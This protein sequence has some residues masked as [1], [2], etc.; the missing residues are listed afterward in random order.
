MPDEYTGGARNFDLKTD[1]EMLEGV[2]HLRVRFLGCAIVRVND[3][4]PRTTNQRQLDSVF[5]RRSKQTFASPSYC[6][7]N[8]LRLARSRPSML[9]RHLLRCARGRHCLGGGYGTRGFAASARRPAEVELTVG[10]CGC[11]LVSRSQTLT[12][13]MRRWKEGLNRRYTLDTELSTV[14]MLRSSHRSH[15]VRTNFTDDED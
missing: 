7:A 12:M 9:R 13:Q 10:Q 15:S 4:T 1:R 8:V 2:A 11:P 14:V 5:S 6:S 3:R